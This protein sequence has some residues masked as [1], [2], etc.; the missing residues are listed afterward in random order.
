MN[1]NQI[2]FL[3]SAELHSE[4][5][6]IQQEIYWIFYQSFYKHHSYGKGYP[7]KKRE[8]QEISS[9]S[10]K[11]TALLEANVRASAS[12]DLLLVLIR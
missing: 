3:K 8:T 6:P 5:I 2:I 12:N 11:N 9:L 4:S 10:Q 7:R 1:T